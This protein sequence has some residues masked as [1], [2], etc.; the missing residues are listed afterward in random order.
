MQIIWAKLKFMDFAPDS[1]NQLYE[2]GELIK[3]FNTEDNAIMYET[4][5]ER[6]DHAL[7]D[8]YGR[9]TLISKFSIFEPT[10]IKLE[11]SKKI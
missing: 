4:A 6:I 3:V 8:E 10:D 2:S 5:Q 1:E 11:L 9:E 7:L